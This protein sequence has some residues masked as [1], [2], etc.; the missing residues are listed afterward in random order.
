VGTEICKI[1]SCGLLPMT[2]GRKRAKMDK[3]MDSYSQLIELVLFV[4]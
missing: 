2:F 3:M 4:Q 1:M